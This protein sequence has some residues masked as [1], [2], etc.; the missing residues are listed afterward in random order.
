MYRQRVRLRMRLDNGPVARHA[1]GR[2]ASA[3]RTPRPDAVPSWASTPVVRSRM[4]RQQ[5]RDTAPELAVRRL[6]HA[7]GLRYRVD[8]APIPELRRRADV[9]FRRVK[10]AVFIDGCFWHGC[11]QH[12]ARRTTANTEYWEAKIVRNQARD[13]DTDRRLRAEGWLSLRVWEHEDAQEASA[14]I[15]AEVRRRRTL[16][17]CERPPSYVRG[18]GVTEAGR[19]P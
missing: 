7:A 14:R 16:G 3:L 8:V 1:G 5:T 11:P 18:N 15:V 6:I 12:G 9:V 19:L 2:P 10:I 4:Q 13:Q 17:T